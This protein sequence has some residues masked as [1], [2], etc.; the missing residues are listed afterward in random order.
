MEETKSAKFEP[1]PR[2]CNPELFRKIMVKFECNMRAKG[3]GVGLKENPYMPN[4]EMDV[5]D[6]TQTATE[7]DRIRAD[8]TRKAIKANNSVMSFLTAICQDN[9]MA[10]VCM[11]KSE[12]A[13]FPNGLAWLAIKNLE[14]AFITDEDV[15]ARKLREI[16]RKVK[17]SDS[18]KP[19]EFIMDV[20]SVWLMNLEIEDE[21]ERMRD[22]E[23][24]E[25]VIDTVPTFYKL[26]V[27]N[28]KAKRGKSIQLSDLQKVMTELWKTEYGKDADLMCLDIKSDIGEGT[29]R[30]LATFG[31]K[32]YKCG[33]TGHRKVDCPTN[34]SGYVTNGQGGN[35]GQ[36]KARFNGKCHCCGKFGHQKKDCFELESNAHKRPAGWK[37]S[38]TMATNQADTAMASTDKVLEYAL[39]AMTAKTPSA[40]ANNI[41]DDDEI[42][43]G[44]TGATTHLKKSMKNV[45]VTT[46]TGVQ[47]VSVANGGM[48]VKCEGNFRCKQVNKNGA[49][50][51]QMC[52]QEI[53]VAPDS[54]VNLFSITKAMKDG[55]KLTE[56][57]PGLVLTKG[58]ASI[59]FDIEVRTEKGSL[60][61]ARLKALED[62]ALNVAGKI[63]NSEENEKNETKIEKKTEK[64]HKKKMNI[65]KAH[66]IYGHQSEKNTREIA[67]ALKQDLT[68]GTLKT[69]VDCAKGKAKQKNLPKAPKEGSAKDEGRVHLDL[70]R[71]LVPTELKFK[72]NNPNWLIVV[73]ERTG[74]K[75]SRFFSSK[76][77]M[78]EPT[79]EMFHLWKELGRAVKIVRC[80]NAGENLLLEQTAN[81]R[82]WKLG[83]M[84][85]YTGRDTPQR[86]ALAEVGFAT[87]MARV[88]AMLSAANL[89]IE[90]RY[91]V[92]NE[93]IMMATIL[94]GLT[95]VDIEGKKATRY[96]H[97]IKTVPKCLK[98]LRIFGEAGVVKTRNVATPKAAD[99]G[100]K[101]MMVG[102]NLDSGDDVY[103][104]W[105]PDTN[106]IL[107]SRDVNWLDAM[108]YPN[109]SIGVREADRY[110]VTP[111][112]VAIDADDDDSDDESIEGMPPLEPRNHDDEDSDSDD[113]DSDYED[114]NSDSN[115]NTD[116][117]D[118]LE[119]PVKTSR[120]G[121]VLKPKRHQDYQYYASEM[122]YYTAM[123][124]TMDKEDIEY[125]TVQDVYNKECAMV[126]AGIGGGFQNTKELRVMKFKEAMANDDEEERRGWQEAVDTEHEKMKKFNVFKPVRKE[127]IPKGTKIITSTWAMKKK[128][129]GTKRA[130]IN[131][132]GFEQ[133]AGVHY[134]PANIAAPVTND[135]SIRIMMT[136][137]LMANWVTWI[138]DVKGAFLHGEFEEGDEPVY[139]EVPEGFEKHYEEPKTFGTNK[140]DINIVLLLLKTIYGLKNAAKAFWNELLKAMKY[141]EFDK[142]NADPCLYWKWTEQGNL[143]TWLSWIDDCACF[144]RPEDVKREVETLKELFDCDD[145]GTMYE[146]VGCKIDRSEDTNGIGEFKFTQ[147]V[148]LQS[149]EDE[150]D[151]SDGTAN[152]T[153]GEPGKTLPVATEE[154]MVEPGKLTYYRSGVG[155][156]LHM[157]RWSR[158]E[159]YNSV[160]D[161]SRH[162]KGCAVVHI[163]AMHRVMR[164]CLKYPNRGWTLR[165]ERKWNG[166][167]QNFEFRITGK[168]DS[169]YANCPTTRRSVTGYSV[170][171][172][173]APIQVK[174]MM[175]RIVALSVT[176]AEINAGVT[177]AQEMIYAKRIIESI[178]LKVKLPMILE[179]DNK[180]AVDHS[181]NFT[182]GGRTKHMETKQLFLRELKEEGVLKIQWLGGDKNDAD[183]FTK[184]LPAA[185]Y[186]KHA[187]VYCGKGD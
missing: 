126:G 42:W 78:V 109:N 13:E 92:V 85:E 28:E 7:A 2:D 125:K 100:V 35:N 14:K 46:K 134:D 116:N 145:V 157:M 87:I 158:P 80:D 30:V 113:D 120:V 180:G 130:R 41:L 110:K 131:A 102:Y 11:K 166:K 182:V 52:L 74:L 95:V 68:R 115:S 181:N 67:R 37:S 153:P 124:N 51:I 128:A 179:I 18:Q 112:A 9:P 64:T 172:E 99:R 119:P 114:E 167:D 170:F 15:N 138:T 20:T 76:N 187:E 139:M 44:D 12:T 38:K 25:H 152:D 154:E 136:L 160:R 123:Y 81:G 143:V 43:I 10:R 111:T 93:C 122:N 53:K 171:L 24:V 176:E 174:S 3:M 149:F 66:A 84:F 169:D 156:L 23:F 163:R 40:T 56:G 16:L 47:S 121:R 146:Y 162:M 62:F 1:I 155:K 159:I 142:S 26:A 107:R 58:D 161:L 185:S 90:V 72:S 144:G 5:D 39:T 32:C 48:N 127:D 108:Y 150:F 104:M 54:T 133:E 70:S 45:E 6:I 69:C 29:E 97:E 103:R 118:E 89:Q 184:N 27:V 106:R 82:N 137:A 22:I 165:P 57:N 59:K 98:H 88:R 33:K 34:K 71:V 117:E 17:M 96:E 105:N 79:C 135:M 94:D 8:K 178:G 83:I 140:D 36:K 19:S 148:M 4:T 60:F 61:C 175:Q 147:P 164:Y 91:R 173:G 49:V 31:G 129:N 55:W 77:A 186:H 183:L 177:C 21:D 101:C 63:D 73:S 50:G 168:S 65:T 75:T 141:M 86:N 132:R 151:L